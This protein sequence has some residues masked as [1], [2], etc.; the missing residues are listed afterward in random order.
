MQNHY[1]YNNIDINYE[2]AQ[3]SI[4]V[5]KPIF[6]DL[7]I[8]KKDDTYIFHAILTAGVGRGVNVTCYAPF[9]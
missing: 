4:H 1:Y 7:F 5:S 9:N 6:A 2:S 3:T 8:G